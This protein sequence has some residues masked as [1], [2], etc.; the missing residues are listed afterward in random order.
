MKSLA[1]WA[2]DPAASDTSG[3]VVAQ[4]ASGYELLRQDEAFRAELLT[5]IPQLKAFARRLTRSKDSG[6]DLAQEALAK[7]WQHQRTFRPGTNLRAWLFTIARNEFYSNRRRARREAPLDQATA[8]SIPSNGV[9]QIWAVDLSD[10]LRA[11]PLLPDLPREA[12]LLAG[13]GGCSY[14]ET[15]RICDCPV[16][17]AKSRVS[18]ARRA[19]LAILESPPSA[20]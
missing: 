11:L 3:A 1:L 19:L 6:E 4:P 8:E 20:G 10:T 13:A 18:R 2:G 15:A 7:A 17:T 5:M 9:D 16:G 14:E 12:L